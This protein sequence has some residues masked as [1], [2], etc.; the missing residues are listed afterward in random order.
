MYAVEVNVLGDTIHTIKKNTD[1]LIDHAG[2]WSGS[3]CR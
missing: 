2:V 3:K 1:I